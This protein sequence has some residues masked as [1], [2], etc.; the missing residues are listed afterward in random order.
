MYTYTMC[1]RCPSKLEEDVKPSR[2]GVPD[3]CEQPTWLLEPEPRSSAKAAWMLLTTEPPVHDSSFIF[4]S[5]DH[6]APASQVEKLHVSEESLSPTKLRR[7]KQILMALVCT[8]GKKSW[9]PA[10]KEGPCTCLGESLTGKRQAGLRDGGWARTGAG[11]RALSVLRS[12][13]DICF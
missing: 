11:H 3:S 6:A 7:E 4:K 9:W 12:L 8:P 2:T 1:A 10:V 13:G 5:W